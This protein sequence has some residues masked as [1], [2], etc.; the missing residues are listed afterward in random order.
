M[1]IKSDAL[2]ALD[3]SFGSALSAIVS[4]GGFEGKQGSSSKVMRVGAAPAQAKYVALVG[5]GKADKLS[6]TSEWGP[7]AFQVGSEWVNRRQSGGP[8]LVAAHHGGGP[9]PSRWVLD[10]WMAVE[11]GAPGLPGRC[12]M[13][14]CTL[15]W[16]LPIYYRQAPV[17]L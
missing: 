2:K 12:W 13:N 10:E 1:E 14:G 8:L 6:T 17:C 3:A 9:L 4:E 5:L 7:S 11:M 15:G 16:G